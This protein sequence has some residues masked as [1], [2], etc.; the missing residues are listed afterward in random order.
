MILLSHPFQ[1]LKWAIEPLDFTERELY[2]YLIG[3]W[4]E[5]D[6]L[7]DFYFPEASK[8]R[9]LNHEDRELRSIAPFK[10]SETI[11]LKT[12]RRPIK[13]INLILVII[14]SLNQ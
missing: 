1:T 10:N 5:L 11:D 12:A 2:T 4:T 8:I 14:I 13:R 7:M 3:L 9:E 6:C